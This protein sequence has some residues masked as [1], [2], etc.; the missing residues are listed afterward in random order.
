MHSHFRS[1][2]NNA[3]LF[4]SVFVCPVSG[5]CFPSGNLIA[6]NDVDV[7]KDTALNWYTNKNSAM[8]AAAARAEDNLC[9]RFSRQGKGNY[10]ISNRTNL[11]QFCNEPTYSAESDILLSL[12]RF[13]I[14]DDTAAETIDTL[15]TK[16]SRK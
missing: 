12:E 16:V 10:N 7:Y 4:T 13:K 3:S 11:H 5:E 1:T 14:L 9:S 8:V 2:K 15:K 6:V